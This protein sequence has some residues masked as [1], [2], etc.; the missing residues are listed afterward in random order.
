MKLNKIDISLFQTMS[1][2]YFNYER[3]QILYPLEDAKRRFTLA[4]LTIYT[5][6]AGGKVKPGVNYT[7][8]NF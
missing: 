2:L 6:R 8:T 4:Q 7:T 3:L 1:R 5:L